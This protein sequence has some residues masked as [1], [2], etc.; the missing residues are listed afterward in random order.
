MRDKLLSTFTAEIKS[1]KY[2]SLIVD[3]APDISH[4][5]QLSFILRHVHNGKIV[6][7]FMGFIKI[8]NHTADYLQELVLNNLKQLSLDIENCGGRSY[9]NAANMFGK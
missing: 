4:C 3:S 5:D 6:E 7:K 9:D 2:F 1:A 8:D